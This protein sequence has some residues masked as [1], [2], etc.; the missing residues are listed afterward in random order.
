MGGE[1]RTDEGNQKDR[2]VSFMSGLYHEA[3]INYYI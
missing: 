1:K 2:V 3:A